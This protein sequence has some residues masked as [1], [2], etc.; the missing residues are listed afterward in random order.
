MEESS[1]FLQDAEKFREFAGWMYSARVEGGA[2][3]KV[4]KRR[5]D[6]EKRR[7]ALLD[8]AMRCFERDGVR[9]VGIEDIRREAGASPSSVYHQFND[10]DD[11][12][13][14]LL[15]RIFA[16][17]FG[18]LELRVR[19]MPTAEQAVCA[20]V[21]GHIEWVANHSREARFMYQAMTLEAGTRR[22]EV[23]AQLVEQK[24]L[25]LQPLLGHLLPF[26]QNGAL[27]PWPPTLFDVVLLGAA[28]EALRRWLAGGAEFDP[29]MLRQTLP[30]LAWKSIRQEEPNRISH[31]D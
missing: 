19:G 21:D 30:R 25:L 29:V 5:K 23:S 13:L 9:G 4:P 26:V 17:L 2:E 15:L 27:P 3:P 18:H 6:G 16:D 7:D 22:P 8:A 1:N 10:V 11:I 28:H 24:A 14:A 12:I 20:L 31:Q